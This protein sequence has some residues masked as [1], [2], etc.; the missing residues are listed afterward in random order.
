MHSGFGRVRDRSKEK[1]WVLGSV[2]MGAKVVNV[3]VQTAKV[4]VRAGGR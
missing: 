3:W 2:N 1:Y 4:S